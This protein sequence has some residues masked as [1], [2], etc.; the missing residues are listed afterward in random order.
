MTSIHF[1]YEQVAFELEHPNQTKAWVES[2]I[3]KEGKTL[4]DINFI[5]CNDEYLLEINLE[6]LGHDTYTDIVTFDQSESETEIAGDIYISIDRVKENTQ[7]FEKQFEEELHRVIIH[8]VLH[9]IGYGDK[10]TIEA[11]EMRKKEEACLSSRQ[12]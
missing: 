7:T 9:L 10:T 6:Y 1:F 8:G 4:G 3:D 11:A 5:F 2:I 12:H